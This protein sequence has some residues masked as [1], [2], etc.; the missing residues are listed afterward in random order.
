MNQKNNWKWCIALAALIAVG[1]AVCFFRTDPPEGETAQPVPPPVP[2]RTETNLMIRPVAP[3]NVFTREPLK[4][5]S[6]QSVSE[7]VLCVIGKD[8]ETA[9]RYLRRTRALATLPKDLPE[10]EIEALLAYLA[11]PTENDPLKPERV[12][13]LKNDIMNLLRSQEPLPAPLISGLIAIYND[14]AQRMVIKDYCVQHLGLLQQQT[15]DEAAL[16]AIDECLRDAARTPG[17]PYAGT[18][19]IALMQRAPLPGETRDYVRQRALRTATSPDSHEA[20]RITAIQIASEMGV[21]ELKPLLR[22]EIPSPRASTSLRTA[23]LGALGLIG[24]TDDAAWLRSLDLAQSPR[25]KI[26][27]ETALRRIQ[28]RHP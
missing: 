4:P 1:G 10:G 16:T 18:A 11:E 26:P 15:E 25:L 9:S 21:G 8:S 19:L 23:A 2:V 6:V 20:A 14:R 7:A 5:E 17:V 3:G 13:A 22:R 12:D 24:D 28:E 27:C